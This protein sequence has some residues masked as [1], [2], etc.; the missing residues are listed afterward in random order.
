MLKFGSVNWELDVLEHHKL[1]KKFNINIKKVQ[2]TN[3]DAAAIAFL[4]DAVDI[5]I[6]DWIWVSKQRYLGK[7][8][9]FL[10]YSSAAG[11][12]IIKNSSKINNI[13]D[14]ENKK[15]G[16]AGGAIDKSWLFLELF[17][18]RNME[19]KLI[20]SLKPHSQHHL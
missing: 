5:F 4:S 6:T 1:D 11:G 9:S 2:M 20:S 3:K 7:K 12:L 17:S 15:V 13:N 14:L 19:R 10:P 16:V 18:K 8:V